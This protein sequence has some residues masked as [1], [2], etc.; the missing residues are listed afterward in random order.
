V[1]K[2]EKKRETKE[3]PRTKKNRTEAKDPTKKAKKMQGNRQKQTPTPRKKNQFAMRHGSGIYMYNPNTTNI[4]KK[5]LPLL[6]GY[7]IE[8]I[9]RLRI[10]FAIGWS[11]YAIDPKYDYSELNIYLGLI[12][13]SIKIF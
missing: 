2:L 4:S 8:M 7:E 12:S 9:N 1:K 10:G 5:L 6:M 11:Y 3:D 13:I